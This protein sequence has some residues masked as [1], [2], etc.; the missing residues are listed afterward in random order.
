MQDFES[1]FI[2][3]AYE[4]IYLLDEQ[5]YIIGRNAC[6]I[7]EDDELMGTGYRSGRGMR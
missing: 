3:R 2:Y 7:C 4:L 5:Y 1:R 6:R